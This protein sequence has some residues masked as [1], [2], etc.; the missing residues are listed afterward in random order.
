MWRLRVTEQEFLAEVEKI[1]ALGAE[2]RKSNYQNEFSIKSGEDGQVAIL[3]MDTV[4]I[5]E[6]R[7]QVKRLN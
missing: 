5:E 7:E 3:L 6:A 2:A 4:T 1:R